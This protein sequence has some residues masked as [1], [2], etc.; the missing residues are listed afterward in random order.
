MAHGFNIEG[1]LHQRLRGPVPP[2]EIAWV[3]REIGGRVLVGPLEED[4]AHCRVNL[5]G[6]HGQ[7]IADQFLDRWLE[8]T[9]RTEYHPYWDLLDVVSMGGSTPYPRLDEFVASAAG[10]L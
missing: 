3:E 6:H 5:S 9:G 2:E 4:V 10:R 1:E 8:A 7:A